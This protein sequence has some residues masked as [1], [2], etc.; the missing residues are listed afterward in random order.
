MLRSDIS[1][2]ININD[3]IWSK[4]VHL[5][6]G[7]RIFQARYTDRWAIADDSGSTPDQTD[8]GILW[9]DQTR[10]LKIET[11]VF[12]AKEYRFIPLLSPTGKESHA[13]T[14]MATMM[15]LSAH[16]VWRIED[17][18]GSSWQVIRRD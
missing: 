3:I 14:N 10:P 18:N 15:Y 6:D 2:S 5:A 7:H 16:F 17:E 8:D 9:L 13:V 11:N 1:T 4:P 12:E